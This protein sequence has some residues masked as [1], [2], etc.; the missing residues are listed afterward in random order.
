M[1]YIFIFSVFLE[2]CLQ[3]Y[4]LVT[5]ILNLVFAHVKPNFQSIR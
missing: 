4:R 1:T 5:G 3:T 2:L